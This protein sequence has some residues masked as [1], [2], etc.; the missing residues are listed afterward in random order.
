MT[1]AVRDRRAILLGA[2]GLLII[3]A[4]HFAVIPWIDSWKD[5]RK[6]IAATRVEL[7]KAQDQIRKVLGQRRRLEEIYGPAVNKALKNR[8]SAQ[9]SL[10]KAVQDVFKTGGCKLTGY[11]PQRCRSLAA[12]PDVELVPLQI[13]AKCQ[14]PQLVKCLAGMQK[15]ETLILVDWFSVTNNEKKPGELE[16]TMMVATLAEK[17]KTKL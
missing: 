13:R 2:V 9:V 4:G 1:L 3:L 10:I 11:Q 14:L 17:E 7:G 8:Q 16:I 12:V 15:S 6:A 5:A